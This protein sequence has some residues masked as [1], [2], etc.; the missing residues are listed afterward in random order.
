M[1]RVI[2]SLCSIAAASCC[3]MP[4]SCTITCPDPPTSC[5]KFKEMTAACGCAASCTVAELSSSFPHFNGNSC[6]AASCKQDEIQCSDGSCGNSQGEC[7]ANTPS[8]PSTSGPA[9][10][11]PCT[12]TCPGPP[13]SCEKFKE[14][15]AAGG[16]AASCTGVVL[17]NSRKKL[18]DCQQDEIQC[19]DGSCGDTQKEC[20]AKKPPA[21][22]ST[23]TG[24]CAGNTVDAENVDCTS[25]DHIK[26]KGA[27]ATGTTVLE[28]CVGFE[29]GCGKTCTS[30]PT[31]CKEFEAMAASTGCASTCAK[32]SKPMKAMQKLVCSTTKER[33]FIKHKMIVRGMKMEIFNNNPTIK[34]VS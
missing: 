20:D 7:D 10:P 22:P 14:M 29:T 9:H 19:S 24:M 17:S 26:N 4:G 32:N 15:T 27:S 5:E 13:T 16:C 23:V 11:A 30:K 18:C 2:L 1:F 6:V 3:E 21:I 31:T 28:C 25:A 12:N 33:F 34:K 8:T